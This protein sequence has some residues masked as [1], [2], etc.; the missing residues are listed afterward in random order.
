M[1]P[2]TALC[3]TVAITMFPQKRE[4]E[5]SLHRI[6]AR[7]NINISE[8]RKN[9]I[10]TSY[11]D[12]YT[13]SIRRPEN[14]TVSQMNRRILAAVERPI[15]FAGKYAIV[16]WSCGAG[17]IDGAIVNQTT[18]AIYDLPFHVTS[19]PYPEGPSKQLHF[20]PFSNLLVVDGALE[21]HEDSDANR[22]DEDCGQRFFLW[23]GTKLVRVDPDA[24]K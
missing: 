8:A 18:K 11:Y 24:K 3:L 14:E 9:L 2:W 17:C 5:L 15:T 1:R 20:T 6:I 12:D 7:Y 4:S 10:P 19:C 16:V 21:W 22:V 13:I 23:T